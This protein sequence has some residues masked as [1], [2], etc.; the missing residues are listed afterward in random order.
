VR[1]VTDEIFGDHLRG[2]GHP[3]SPDR[4]EVVTLQEAPRLKLLSRRAH[5]TFERHNHAK[6]V[7]GEH[8]HSDDP[9]RSAGI[10][11]HAWLHPAHANAM[12]EPHEPPLRIA[13]G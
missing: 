4:V 8:G 12:V 1:V 2:I 9:G 5:A 6:A 10:D 3:E 11:G 7:N 13:L